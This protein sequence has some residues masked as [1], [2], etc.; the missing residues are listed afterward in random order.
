MREKVGKLLENRERMG[1]GNRLH[2]Y[3]KLVL[4]AQKL[5]REKLC[6]TAATEVTA[7]LKE[8]LKNGVVFSSG[9]KL[10]LWDKHTSILIKEGSSFDKL[11]EASRPWSRPTDGQFDVFSPILASLIT[12]SSD[13]RVDM[14]RK[15]IFGLFLVPRI[16][17]ES[18]LAA[19]SE[20][21][22]ALQ[23][24]CQ[25]EDPLDMDETEAAACSES[26]DACEIITAVGD[27]A[28]SA[29][30]RR[31]VAL[32]SEYKHTASRGVLC[33]VVAALAAIDTVG[34][35]MEEVDGCQ[36][37]LQE[38]GPQATG[39]VEKVQQHTLEWEGLDA[40]VELFAK[41]KAEL[42]HRT[43]IQPLAIAEAAV[44]KMR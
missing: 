25:G 37:P 24:F 6:S 18:G 44:K 8:L 34:E 27:M 17:N 43:M 41:A 2:A 16:M 21:V 14:Y 5:R 15:C 7:P 10:N 4:A 42:P 3:H 12:L 30:W 33:S 39:V 29:N 23:A 9:I 22:R 26:M 31:V 19:V 28:L 13:A 35:L 32:F 40:T 38:L 36:A 11:L 20:H 1:E